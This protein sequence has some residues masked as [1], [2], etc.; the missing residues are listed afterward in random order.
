MSMASRLASVPWVTRRGWPPWAASTRS[1]PA[2]F[3]GL[4]ANIVGG[5]RITETSADLPL[6]LAA[7]SSLRGKPLPE[8]TVIFGEVGLAGEIRPVQQGEERLR[9]AAKQGFKQAIVPTANKPRKRAGIDLA[10]QPVKRLA[11]AVAL[12]RGEG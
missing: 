5:M 6:L 11:E 2:R 4:F 1:M 10:V 3:R 8:A 12:A 9:E 7:V